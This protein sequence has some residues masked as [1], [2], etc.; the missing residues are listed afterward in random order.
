MNR[1]IFTT[2]MILLITILLVFT[3]TPDGALLT[4]LIK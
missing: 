2:G 1:V 4:T 3:E